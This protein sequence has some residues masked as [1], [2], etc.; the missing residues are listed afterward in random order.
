ML[1]FNNELANINDDTTFIDEAKK[2][3]NK[4]EVGKSAWATKTGFS[5]ETVYKKMNAS[6][7]KIMYHTH[8]CFK[9]WK[10]F[11][12]DTKILQK[13]L[14]DNNLT[15]DRFGVSIDSSMALPEEMRSSTE[16]HSALFFENEEDWK[17]LSSV[18][19]SQ[20]HLGDNMIGSPS[21]YDSCINALKA[22][23][24]TMGN[25][26]QFFGWDY[27]QFPNVEERTKYTI[28]A[29]AVM[30]AHKKDGALIHSNLDDGYGQATSKIS[31]LLGMAILEKYIVCD[32]L[33]ATLAP[34]FGDD[35]HSP[36]KRLIMLS[37]LSQLYDGD[38]VGSMLFENKLGRNKYNLKLND[39]HLSECLL[40]DMAGQVHYKTGHAVT[41]MAN[42]GLTEK[43]KPEE[44]VEKL[45][46]A[47]E[48]ESY[49]PEIL[50][51][52]DFEKIDKIA[53]RELRKGK[54]FSEAVLNAFSSY[55]D[56]SNPYAVMLAIKKVGVKNLIDSFAYDNDAIETDFAHF[57]H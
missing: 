7:G 30:A 39:S 53:Y 8:F 20:V 15:L 36:Y 13:S 47:K 38:L 32:L 41:V 14:N 45:A 34:S 4:I 16:N 37:A 23:V 12:E 52:I 43:V 24:T 29:I 31:E 55:I 21:S 56:I 10:Q 57:E 18:D 2:E 44:I 26:S 48:L 19:F 22:G 28:K 46:M 50:K 27:E 42:E 1:D 54:H 51:V 35:F 33:G 3:A 40:F 25:I 17:H 11:D 5:N 9:D 49:V 6:R